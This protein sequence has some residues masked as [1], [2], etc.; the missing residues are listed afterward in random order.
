M[1]QFFNKPLQA[2]PKFPMDRLEV[3]AT[4]LINKDEI[5]RGEDWMTFTLLYSHVD[6]GLY[7][8]NSDR[9]ADAFDLNSDQKFVKINGVPNDVIETLNTN[10]DD[11]KNISSG[12]N[13]Q[14]EDNQELRE[15]LQEKEECILELKGRVSELEKLVYLLIGKSTS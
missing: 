6:G 8:G 5:S 14:I 1:P 10:S 3:V 12:L 11:I 13:S 2:P 9:I 7:I 15:T 4:D